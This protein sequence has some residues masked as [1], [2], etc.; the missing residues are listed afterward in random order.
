MNLKKG[1][2]VNR[3]VEIP[4]ELKTNTERIAWLGENIRTRLLTIE[5]ASETKAKAKADITLYEEVLKD[6]IDSQKVATKTH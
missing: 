1:S 2:D 6:I 5:R 3:F 4:E